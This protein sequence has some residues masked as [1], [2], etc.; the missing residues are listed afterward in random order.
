MNKEEKKASKFYPIIIDASVFTS[1]KHCEALLQ[2]NEQF[3]VSNTQY[4]LMFW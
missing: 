4:D 3:Y 1:K 2:K